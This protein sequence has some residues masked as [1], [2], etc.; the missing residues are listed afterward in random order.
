MKTTALPLAT[1]SL[2]LPAGNSFEATIPGSHQP[3]FIF[4]LIDDMPWFG[5]AVRL[6]AAL[7]E[8]AMDFR[9]MPNVA[10]L[11]RLFG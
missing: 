1:L 7:P 3:N 8:S 10:K 6:D 2:L 4:I 11:D 5:T 9:Q